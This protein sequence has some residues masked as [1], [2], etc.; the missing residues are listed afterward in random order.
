[1]TNEEFENQLRQVPLAMPDPEVKQ[2]L[3]H[4]A[5]RRARTQHRGRALRWAIA[6]AAGVLIV[7][8]VVFGHLHEQRIT[9]VTGR[10]AISRPMPGA[11]YADGLKEMERLMSEVLGENGNS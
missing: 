2:R 11:A 1:M 3:M 10:P 4:R 7:T 6:A 8:N 9:Q 5:V